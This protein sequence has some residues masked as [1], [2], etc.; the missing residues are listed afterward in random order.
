MLTLS[1]TRDPNGK[2]C[3]YCFCPKCLPCPKHDI[4]LQSLFWQWRHYI[5]DRIS[6]WTNM[7]YGSSLNVV[8]LPPLKQAFEVWFSQSHVT[9]PWFLSIGIRANFPPSGLSYGGA[10]MWATKKKAMD[11]PHKR[12]VQVLD[13]HH[14]KCLSKHMWLSYGSYQLVSESQEAHA[15]SDE[16]RSPSRW[17]HH[18]PPTQEPFCKRQRI[19]TAPMGTRTPRTLV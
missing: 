6:H 19:P 7:N 4:H 8:R 16:S 13:L 14:A 5:T 10:S 1:R 2:I 15:H 9:L 18:Q 3:K 12:L 17:E 11:E